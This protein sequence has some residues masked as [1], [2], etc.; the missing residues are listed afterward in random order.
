MKQSLNIEMSLDCF[1]SLS[2]SLKYLTVLYQVCR[3]LFVVFPCKGGTGL[4]PAGRLSNTQT[5]RIDTV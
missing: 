3:N 1:I 2:L 4:N 5:G